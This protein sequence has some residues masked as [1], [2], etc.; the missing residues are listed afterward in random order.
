[1]SYTLISLSRSVVSDIS[2]LPIT[3]WSSYDVEK[4]LTQPSPPHRNI[5]MHEC[6]WYVVPPTFLFFFSP[7]LHGNGAINFLS[8]VTN[9]TSW[10]KRNCDRL[11]PRNV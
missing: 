10:L 7:L 6:V 11:L 3:Q 2:L 1:M 4:A 8:A 5:Q 9:L